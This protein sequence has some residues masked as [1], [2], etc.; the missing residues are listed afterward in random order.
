[1][2]FLVTDKQTWTVLLQLFQPFL[3]VDGNKDKDDESKA[4]Q[5]AKAD[6]YSDDDKEDEK[7]TEKLNDDE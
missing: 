2:S 6:T 7:D 5:E 1:M 3:S 4:I